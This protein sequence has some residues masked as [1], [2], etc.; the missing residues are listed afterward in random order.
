VQ[1]IIGGLQGIIDQAMVGLLR[2]SSSVQMLE[3]IDL[4]RAFPHGI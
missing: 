1:G 3:Y 4:L 2:R